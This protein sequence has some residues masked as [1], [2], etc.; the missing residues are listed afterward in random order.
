MNVEGAEHWT[1]LSGRFGRNDSGWNVEPVPIGSDM[2]PSGCNDF[3]GYS[4]CFVTS[5]DECKM[6]QFIDLENYGLY[7]SIMDKY[8]PIIVAS[9]W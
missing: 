8:Q 5:C 7:G 4:S 9:E 1:I 2:L 3:D 6:E